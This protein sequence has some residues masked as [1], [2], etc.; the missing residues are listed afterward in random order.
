MTVQTVFLTDNDRRRLGT[1]LSD[2]H[3]LAEPRSRLQAL[4]MDLEFAEV[5]SAEEIP[6]DV[7]TM[8]STVEIRD[9]ESGD[10][11]TYTLVY[12]QDADVIA[13]R[14][15]ILAPVGQALLGKRVGDEVQVTTPS[16]QRT[17]RI[18]AIHFQPERAGAYHL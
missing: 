13:N 7:V 6:A 14:I 8:N 4:E 15:S 11:E 1:V 18:E 2:V 3:A 12:P 5:L 17:I 16:G 9:F 10:T